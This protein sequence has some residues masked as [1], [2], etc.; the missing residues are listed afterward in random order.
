MEWN[1]TPEDRALLEYRASTK[2]CPKCGS[3]SY[4]YYKTFNE[5]YVHESVEHG[6]EPSE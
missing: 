5:F 2:A 1:K 6:N 3:E 4:K